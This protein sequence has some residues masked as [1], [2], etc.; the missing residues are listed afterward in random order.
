MRLRGFEVRVLLD[1]PN[2]PLVATEFKPTPCL[3]GTSS[4]TAYIEVA[5]GKEYWLQCIGDEVLSKKNARGLTF[6]IDGAI[7][8]ETVVTNR[9]SNVVDVKLATM[10]GWRQ[11]RFCTPSSQGQAPYDAKRLEQV[12]SIVVQVRGGVKGGGKNA[13]QSII[14]PEFIKAID[15]SVARAALATCVGK[16][17]TNERGPPVGRRLKGKILLLETFKFI[18]VSHDE[19]ASVLGTNEFT[20]R[21]QH[22]PQ[23][24]IKHETIKQDEN[25]DKPQAKRKK[26]KHEASEAKKSAPVVE[27]KT[28]GANDEDKPVTK[29]KKIKHEAS[30]FKKATPVVEGKTKNANAGTTKTSRVRKEVSSQIQAMKK[31]Q[32]SAPSIVDLTGENVV[33]PVLPRKW[34]ARHEACRQVQALKSA[35]GPLYLPALDFLTQPEYAKS[36]VVI[37]AADQ[38]E[39]LEWKLRDVPRQI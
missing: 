35:L 14:K 25:A 15:T 20:Q 19:L 9:T 12:G 3:S 21:H 39:W 31:I 18:Y 26:I 22:F 29:R 4:T 17:T 8:A 10:S 27:G 5:A 16:S 38:L 36:F 7:V 33:Q 1:E 34:S 32:A 23:D 28:N 6:Y 2:G 30:G 37:A 11:F 13:E 24:R